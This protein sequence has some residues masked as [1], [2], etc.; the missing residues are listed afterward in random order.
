MVQV[1]QKNS[2][3][4]LYRYLY[5]VSVEWTFQYFLLTGWSIMGEFGQKILIIVMRTCVIILLIFN[6]TCDHD[7]E[8]CRGKFQIILLKNNNKE[9]QKIPRHGDFITTKTL[10][11]KRV[12]YFKRMQHNCRERPLFFTLPNYYHKNVLLTRM[13][14]LLIH[15]QIIQKSREDIVSMR[16]PTNLHLLT[17]LTA[18]Q[19]GYFHLFPYTY[20]SISTVSA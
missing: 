13:N 2:K 7:D 15:K 18:L 8:F 4:Y 12:S 11:Y 5:S 1:T 10:E 19:V 14:T 9:I 3:P 20:I 17:A 6:V 16:S